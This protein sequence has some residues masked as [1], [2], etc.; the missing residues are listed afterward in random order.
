[1][2]GSPKGEVRHKGEVFELSILDGENI[3]LLT[4]YL[5]KE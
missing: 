1:M 2:K 3:L 5:M 4:K